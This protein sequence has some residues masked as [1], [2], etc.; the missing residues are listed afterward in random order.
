MKEDQIKEWIEGILVGDK[1]SFQSLYK[2]TCEDV[3]RTVGFLIIDKQDIDD[4]VNE[5]Y[6]AMWKSISKYDTN[7]SFRF[8]LHGLIVRQTQDWRRKAWRRFRILER[9]KAFRQE[10]SYIDEER[11]LHKEMQSELMQYVVALSN[12]HR[13]IIILRYY[14]DYSLDAISILL[15]I[16]I[17]TVK[18][19]LH[20]ALKKLRNKL[21]HA[22]IIE[23]GEING[24]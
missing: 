23:V 11:I 13:E 20:T 15:N 8:W 12:K 1:E 5:V 3:Y 19:R 21:E 9:K 4:V 14:H 6:I 2:A 7:R 18:S 16:P 22:K 17:G 10:S 24:C